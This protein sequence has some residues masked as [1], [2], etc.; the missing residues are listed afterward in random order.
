[1]WPSLPDRL[2]LPVQL[3]WWSGVVSSETVGLLREV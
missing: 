1:M 2:R 3:R